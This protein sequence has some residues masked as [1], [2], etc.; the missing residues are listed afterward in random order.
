[1]SN[2]T[3][4]RVM[5]TGTS[6]GIGKAIADHL[7]TLGLNILGVDI[8][9]SKIEHGCYEHQILDLTDTKALQ[10]AFSNLEVDAFI[11]A[12]GFLRVGN[13]G[14]LD[15]EA[16]Q[17]MWRLHTQAAEIITNA[18]IPQMMS[19]SKG[20]IIYI[21]S[22]V[23]NGFP[24]RSQYAA[25]K[26]ALVAMAKSYAIEVAQFGITINVVSPAATQTSMTSD[27][28]RMASQPKLP[29]IGRLINPQ[30]IAELVTFLLSTS[31]AAI[32]GQEI[33]ICGGSSLNH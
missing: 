6:S 23:S 33:T 2:N 1:M 20:R 13:V 22:R 15:I 29:P 24:G 10:E 3:Y 19:R 25:T 31:A 11:H 32:T 8:S 9:S 14:D 16:G 30:E 28:S 4:Q 17:N 12:A 26:A 27:P 5:V 7:L 18:L 21:G